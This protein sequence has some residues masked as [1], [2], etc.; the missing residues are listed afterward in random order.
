MP[1]RDKAKCAKDALEAINEAL[2]LCSPKHGTHDS[3]NT[4]QRHLLTEI[5]GS[6]I[7]QFI[8]KVKKDSNIKQETK[9]LDPGTKYPICANMKSS[10]IDK[11][12]GVEEKMIQQ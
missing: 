9:L 4:G 1:R 5:L 12:L 8:Q 3:C 11:V 6:R 7:N 10:K 2:A